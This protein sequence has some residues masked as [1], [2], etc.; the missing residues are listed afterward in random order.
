M[1]VVCIDSKERIGGIPSLE[2]VTEGKVYEIICH[3]ELVGNVYVNII[4]NNGREISIRKDRFKPLD[5]IRLEK[6]EEILK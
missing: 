1:K 2:Y 4:G 5:E 3:H 6:L